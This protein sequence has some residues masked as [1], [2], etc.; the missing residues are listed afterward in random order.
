M[1]FPELLAGLTPP[2]ED[3]EPDPAQ[4]RHN[5]TLLYGEGPDPTAPSARVPL[6]S[7]APSEIDPLR[8]RINDLLHQHGVSEDGIAEYWQ[9]MEGKYPDLDEPTV[10]TMLYEQLQTAAE[11]RREEGARK[12][13]SM[14][15]DMST[16]QD[17]SQVTHTE[18][19]PTEAPHGVGNEYLAGKDRDLFLEG[20]GVE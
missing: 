10:L 2:P 1:Y 17:E 3:A 16:S 4:L 12:A 5:V 14:P 18:K 8:Q 13:P 11:K 7:V 15:Q 19:K 9:K 6:M 20:E